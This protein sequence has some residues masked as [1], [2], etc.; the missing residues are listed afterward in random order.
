MFENNFQKIIVLNFF[1]WRNFRSRLL[2]H[3]RAT[4]TSTNFHLESIP[5]VGKVVNCLL[6][7]AWRFSNFCFQI[8]RRRSNQPVKLSGFSLTKC[9]NSLIPR[10]LFFYKFHSCS[11]KDGGITVPT[12]T[13]AKYQ[14]P[15]FVASPLFIYNV[16]LGLSEYVTVKSFCRSS[17]P[18]WSNKSRK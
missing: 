1:C 2:A 18:N 4:G 13:F 11:R 12:G 14:P 5:G 8:P 15:S 9:V 16:L 10:S 7:K 17:T 6:Q 3:F